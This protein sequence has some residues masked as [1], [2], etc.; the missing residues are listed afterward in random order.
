MKSRL[1]PQ[2]LAAGEQR[3]ERCLLESCA[4]RRT[5]LRAFLDDVE[6]GDARAAVGRRQ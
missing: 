1:Q 4:D 3:V 6:A 5:H 2:V